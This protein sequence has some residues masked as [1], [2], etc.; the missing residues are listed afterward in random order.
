MAKTFADVVRFLVPSNIQ[1]GDGA[2]LLATIAQ[3]QDE[4]I[5]R[6][7]N[8]LNARVPTRSRDDALAL[9]GRDRG[10]PRGRAETSAHYA[11]RLLRWRAPRGHRVRGNAFALLEQ[12]SEYWG[13]QTCWLIDTHG[14]RWERSGGVEATEKPFAWTWDSRPASEWSRFWLALDLAG[15]AHAHTT[16][17]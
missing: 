17:F 7:R 11:Q 15:I 6:V 8:G 13:G 9:V 2:A 5:T 12:L 4:Q 14:R 16:S 3:L 10:I 1:G